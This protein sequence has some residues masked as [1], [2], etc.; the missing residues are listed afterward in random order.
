M[1]G[2]LS[3]IAGPLISGVSGYFAKKQEAKS[4]AASAAAK[5]AMKKETGSQEIQLTDAEWESIAAKGQG[6]TWK[7]EYL[8]LVISGPIVGVLAGSVWYAF[9][10]NSNLLDGT[11]NGVREL[12]ELGL[13]WDFL[14]T[15]VVLAGIG[16]KMWRAK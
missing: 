13:D 7:D 5:L 2:I 1:L 3:T 14:T 4:A 8:T 6:D 10:G 15:S 16:L 12:R 9:T 11:L